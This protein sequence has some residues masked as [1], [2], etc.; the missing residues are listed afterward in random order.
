MFGE[1]FGA[2][3]GNGL[4]WVIDPIDGTRAFMTGMLHW[5]LL[6][7]LFDGQT[8]VL[9]VMHQPFTG[10]TFYGDNRSAR[11]RRAGQ[12]RV[13]RTRQGVALDAAVLTT[14][15]PRLFADG[16]ERAAF[17]RLERAVKLSKYGGDCYIY[18]MVAMGYVDLASDAGLK[19]YDIQALMPII[20]GAGGTVT[21]ME[22]GDPSMGGCILA[23]GSAELH[24]QALECAGRDD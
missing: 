23:S 17:D 3:S 2:T 24:R 16:D 6:L 11:Y 21:T 7:A 12:E 4:T 10:E 14:T 19:P 8:P 22:G 1:E 20:R 5:G 13:L 15:S 18:A 9:G